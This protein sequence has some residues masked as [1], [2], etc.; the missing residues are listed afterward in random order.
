MLRDHLTGGDLDWIHVGA[1]PRFFPCLLPESFQGRSVDGEEVG[2]RSRTR[3]VP[4]H[5]PALLTIRNGSRPYDLDFGSSRS[6]RSKKE[7]NEEVDL[8]KYSVGFSRGRDEG[9]FPTFGRE[10]RR[11]SPSAVS[12]GRGRVV[13]PG[14]TPRGYSDSKRPGR[15]FGDVV[16]C[17]RF[18]RHLRRDAAELFPPTVGWRGR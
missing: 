11:A 16:R 9:A 15:V 7:V 18:A 8:K 1:G 2:R 6:P 12:S 13:G 3:Q 10:Q 17:A 4:S 5:R 14:S